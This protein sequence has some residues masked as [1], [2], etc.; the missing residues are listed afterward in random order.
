VSVPLI[1]LSWGFSFADTAS[2]L[3]ALLFGFE[4]GQVRI[5]LARIV[6]ALLL[7]FAFYFATRLLQRWLKGTVLQP[8]RMDAGIA[9]SIH[10]G[11][12]YAGI[13][14]AALIAISYGG[15]DITNLAIVAGALSVGI[16]FGLQS[17]VNNFVSGLILLVERPVKV[18]DWI[19]VKENEGHVRRISVRS[20]EIETFDK[21]SVIVPNSDLI[22][23]A[24]KNWTHRNSL[25]RTT[26]TVKTPVSSDPDQ[27]REILLKAA[28]ECAAVLK[29]PAPQATFDH[30]SKDALEFSLN[31][32]VPDV[33][34]AAAVE[35]ELRT[36]VFKAFKSAGIVA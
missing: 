3:K 28:D 7:F 23:H 34:R 29:H 19:V 14:I 5:S 9:H 20:T 6:F 30:F 35:T 22:Q 17:I 26:I 12:G 8:T 16:G 11:I 25:G 18:G 15:L 1:L 4:I 32:V 24:V 21:A 31:A 2:W 13:G 10:T 27:V 36:A 33:N